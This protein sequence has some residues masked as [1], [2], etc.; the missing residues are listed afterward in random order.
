MQ[1]NFLLELNVPAKS[2]LLENKFA[3]T[4]LGWNIA[5]LGLLHKRVIGECHPSFERLL[6]WYTHRFESPRG[7]GHNK[8]LYGHWLEASHHRALY[9]RSIFAMVNIYDNLPQAFVDACSV[10]AFQKWLTSL[11]RERCEQDTPDWAMSFCC[12]RGP[13]LNVPYIS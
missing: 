4:A 7:L 5:I 12:R 2:I 3:S 10:T 13:D 11:T 8:Q 9:N 1:R 6:P